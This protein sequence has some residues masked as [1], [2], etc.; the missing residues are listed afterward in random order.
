MI[1]KKIKNRPHKNNKG[2]AILIAIFSL[3]ILTFIALEV[4]YETNV[5]YVVASQKVNRLKE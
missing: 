1:K 3:G 4:S 5:E 2:I